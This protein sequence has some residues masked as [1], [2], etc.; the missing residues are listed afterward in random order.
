[1]ITIEEPSHQFVFSVIYYFYPSMDSSHFWGF[2]MVATFD[3]HSIDKTL[4]TVEKPTIYLCFD[5][6]HHFQ[7]VPKSA[8]REHGNNFVS[9][10][11]LNN[12]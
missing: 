5:S 2:V 9:V 12:F 8:W 1:M 11:E 7:I 3:F 10:S 4:G 6:K